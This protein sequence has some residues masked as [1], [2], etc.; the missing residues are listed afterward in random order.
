MPSRYRERI[1]THVDALGSDT[2]VPSGPNAPIFLPKEFFFPRPPIPPQSTRDPPRVLYV[3]H[4]HRTF[5]PKA[6]FSGATRPRDEYVH[7]YNPCPKKFEIL[8]GKRPTSEWRGVKSVST[9]SG[10]QEILCL[11][12]PGLY[13]FLKRSD[14]PQDLPSLQTVTRSRLSTLATFTGT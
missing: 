14:K 1:V 7:T 12:E 9:P 11:F 3:N 13:F 4:S 8:A 10:I 6:S 2:S 5:P